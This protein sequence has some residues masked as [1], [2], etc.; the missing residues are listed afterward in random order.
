MFNS[1][2]TF[3]GLAIA[4]TGAD[5]WA[6][7]GGL[8]AVIASNLPDI[9]IV[10]AAAGTTT[11][12]DYHRGFTHTLLGVPVLSLLFAVAMY[13]VSREFFRTFVVALIAMATHPA[14]DYAN[15]YGLR[16]FLPFQDTWYYG[17][18]LFII[19][20]Y[21]DL[22]FLLGILAGS[23]FRSQRKVMAWIS[24]ALVIAYIGARVE[25]HSMAASHM[26]EFAQQ[27]PAAEQWA[28]FPTILNPMLW[29]GIIQTKTEVMTRRL[30]ARS[31]IQGGVDRLSRGPSSGIVESAAKTKSAD[32]LLRF[33]R[34]P[35]ARVEDFG[36]GGYRV[37]FF[38]FRFYNDISGTALGAEII[39]DESLHVLKEN[40]SFT[41]MVK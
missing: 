10:T 2:H 7:Y 4:R 39:L 17:D 3:V 31:G 32:V 20:P 18:V 13:S 14:L 30:N 1:T 38:D 24:L 8:T 11:Y 21:I 27:T 41:Q 33:S 22:I 6:P 35:V 16:P 28:V 40:L 36:S 26:A 23:S 5:K 25:L 19:D 15:T 29:T 37:R 9:D 34:F 12:I